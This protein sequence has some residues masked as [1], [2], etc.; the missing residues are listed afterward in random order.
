MSNVLLYHT[1]RI[2]LGAI[3]LY[4]S[5][6]KIL[7][8][9]AFAEAVY[10]YQILPDSM[11]NLTAIVL[12]WLEALLGICFFAGVWM[13]GVSVIST[14]LLGVF[15]GALIF[16][17]MRGIDVHCGCFSTQSSGDPAGMLWTVARDALFLFFSV[18]LTVWVF[19]LHPAGRLLPEKQRL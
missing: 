8:P 10:N 18:Y 12:P 4:A 13:P 17:Q 9:Q 2:I 11:I 3:F 15:I 19:F 1:A 7:H 14:G 16:N 6:D 5:F